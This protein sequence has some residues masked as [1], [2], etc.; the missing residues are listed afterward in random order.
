MCETAVSHRYDTPTHFVE[1]YVAS[2]GAGL[3]LCDG[4]V[5]EANNRS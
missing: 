5:P 4:V 1:G 2:D 3:R